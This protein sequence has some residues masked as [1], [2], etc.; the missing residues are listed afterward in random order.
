MKNSPV[1]FPPYFVRIV[2]FSVF[3][4]STKPRVMEGH[5]KCYHV[6]VWGSRGRCLHPINQK[7]KRGKK[8]ATRKIFKVLDLEFSAAL[9]GRDVE[10]LHYLGLAPR[11]WMKAL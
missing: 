8:K 10:N 5:L 3:Q 1:I 4:R 2:K 9:L 6:S 7:K 11:G